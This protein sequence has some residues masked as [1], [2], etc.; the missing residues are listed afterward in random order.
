[1]STDTWLWLSL[2]PRYAARIL[3]DEKHIELR[4]ARPLQAEGARALLYAS[5]PV[6][7]LLGECRITGVEE[8]PPSRLWP[9][10]SETAGVNQV[11]YDSYFAGA[12]RAVALQLDEVVVWHQPVPLATIR[13]LWP[14]FMPPQSFRYL[15]I[16]QVIELRSHTIFEDIAAGA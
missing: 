11:E 8:G 10:V 15:S 9:R 12:T 5:S 2:Q 7:A 1:M 4:R 16:S 14:R 6:M 3:A 13:R